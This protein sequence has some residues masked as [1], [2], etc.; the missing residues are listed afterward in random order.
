MFA[1]LIMFTA[2][3]VLVVVGFDIAL[4]MILATLAY[5][6]IIFAREGQDLTAA[7]T[8]QMGD[9]INQ[10]LLF[11][12][13]LF[14]L[15][16][17]LMHI[18]GITETL[19]RLLLKALRWLPGP[20]GYVNVIANLV[21]SGM[22]GSAVADAAATS[23]VLIRPMIRTGYSGAE[24][25]ALT[26]AAATIGPI[27]PPSIPFVLIGGLASISIGQLFVAGI[28]PGFLMAGVLLVWVA[29]KAR[30]L[31]RV[32]VDLVFPPYSHPGRAALRLTFALAQP[33]VVMGAL[34]TGIATVTEAAAIGCGLAFLGLVTIFEVHNPRTLFHVLRDSAMTIGSVLIMLGASAAIGWILAREG[35]G[36]LLG[37]F[38]L[39][40]AQSPMLLWAMIVGVLLLL[41]LA[42]EP[43]P[44]ILILTP[45]IYPQLSAL[46]IHPIHFSV[47]MTVTLMIGLIS[48]PV[49]LNLFTVAQTSGVPLAPMMRASWPY[50]GVLSVAAFLLA[51]FPAISLWL[52]S[53]FF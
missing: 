38:L 43:I 22:S 49:G 42:L 8:Q 3:I 19:M 24:A 26:A 2:M 40:F 13:P 35:F 21:I 28:V 44:L 47:V 45:I 29:I 33:F 7:V 20:L 14:V 51:F 36:P 41:G 18:S 4:A 6:A 1:A 34:V 50:V 31:P 12:V 30:G 11:A 46:Q 39:Q 10:E 32:D 25:G 37:Q 23:S 16:G 17:N 52:P 15:M 27:I 5:M 53:L 9:G 48:P